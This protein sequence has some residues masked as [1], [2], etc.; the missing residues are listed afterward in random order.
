[1]NFGFSLE[2]GSVASICIIPKEHWPQWQAESEPQWNEGYGCY[3]KFNSTTA[4]H[5][6]SSAIEIPAG[7]YYYA[8][9]CHNS[10]DPCKIGFS[11]SL[12]YK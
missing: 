1:V 3:A 7:S 2:K 4:D 9:K 11:L 10:A 8:F 12:E 6:I 5:T